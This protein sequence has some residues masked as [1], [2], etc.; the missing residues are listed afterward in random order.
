MVDRH[1]T[2]TGLFSALIAFALANTFAGV[3]YRAK[4]NNRDLSFIGKPYFTFELL[5]WNKYG[6]FAFV[7]IALLLVVIVTITFLPAVNRY[8]IG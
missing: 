1:T 2:S 3:T 4:K 7:Q 6:L 5:S 8:C